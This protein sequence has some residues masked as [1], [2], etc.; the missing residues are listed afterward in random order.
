MVLLTI[1]GSLLNRQ[2]SDV[3]RNSPIRFAQ[4]PNISSA[5]KNALIARL[6]RASYLLEKDID[7]HLFAFLGQ[8]TGQFRHEGKSASLAFPSPQNNRPPSPTKRHEK[9]RLAAA[10]TFI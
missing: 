1:K 7:K 9:K 5:P 8:M 6:R 3:V 4:T 2:S 10:S